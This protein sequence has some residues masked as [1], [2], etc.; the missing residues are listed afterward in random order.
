MN[1][2]QL[3]KPLDT[4]PRRHIGPN[5]A[6][7]EEMLAFLG[8]DSLDDL[9][10]RVVPNT[11]RE[12]PFLD[13]SQI[14]DGRGEAELLAELKGMAQQNQVLR[15]YLGM[16]YHG[17]LTPGVVLRNLLENPGWYTAY[18]PYQA[19]IAQGR[20]EMLLA[21]QTLVSDLTG[22][23]IS[24]ASL[25]DEATA[26]AE[27]VSL[28]DR[29]K[30]RKNKA[31]TFFVDERC[32]PQ[33]IAVVKTR[34]DAADV[35][36]LV[37]DPLTF[38]FAT[39]VFGVLVQYPATDGEIVDYRELVK[40][41]HHSQALAVF[42][43]DLLALTLLTPPGELGADVVIGCS[44]R[45][46][47]PM[48]FGG[49]HAAFMAT[50]EAYKR[51]VPGRIIGVSQD[52]HGNPALRM[53]L[54]TR[55]QH[56]RRQ[57]ATSNICTAQV[58]LAVVAAAY[59]IYH[60]PEGITAIAR[61]V[62]GMTALL[63][64]ELKARGL[65]LVHE[66]Y[67]DTLRVRGDHVAAALAAGFNL[68]AYQGD[69][70]I[71]LDETVTEQDL[72]DLLAV[73]DAQLGAADVDSAIP[74]GLTRTSGFL[75]N[76]LF[77]RYHSEHE[78]LRLLRKLQGRDL[79]LDTSMIALGSCTMKLNA[80]CQ[81]IPVTWPEFGAMHPFAPAEQTLGYAKLFEQLESWLCAIT[82][83][84]AFSLQPNAGSQGEYAGLL[85]IRGYHHGRG[86]DHRN[87]CLIPTSAHGTNPASAVMVGMKVVAVK[88]DDQ[89]NIDLDDLRAQAA[90]YADNLAALM[91]T[92]PSTHGVFETAIRDICA[93]VHEHGGQ[94]YLDGANMNAQVG[95]ARPGHYGADV[96]HLNLHKTFAIPHGGGGPGMGPIGVRAHLA[97]Y[98]PGHPERAVS[99]APYGSP[100]ILP[101]SWMYIA[102][103]G[104]DGLR[105]STQYA[106]LNANYIARKLSAHFDVLYTGP[107][108]WVAHECILDTRPLKAH[109][110]E[111]DDIA[112]RLMDFGFH[113]PT[114]SFPVSG[115]LMV[116]P[117]ESEPKDELDRFC[118]ALIAIKGEA[119]AIQRGEMDPVD[120]PLKNA[121]HTQGEI[122]GEWTHP[123]SR[124]LAAF[125]APWTRDHKYWP[126]V[127]RIDNA[128]GDRNL[129]CTCPSVEELSED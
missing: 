87:I 26:A 91:V 95:I 123:Y 67:F 90:R 58:L 46:G 57:K 88:C 69:T 78:M 62:H 23:E 104:A 22:M 96:C 12:Q 77:N 59:A 102:A 73:F 64:R 34:A 122:V 33:T 61:R 48:G 56:I 70:C 66:H 53:A 30:S 72:R 3:L 103:L 28:C 7:L 17:T 76:E 2:E 37:G 60:G 97:P 32:H 36:I 109:G 107:G 128:W 84:D 79:A 82:G 8:V 89:G 110:V 106:I 54:Q 119:D 80:T 65:E 45:F 71:A 126:T 10:S 63:A 15:S 93:V 39:P 105:K 92:Y 47:V 114:M 81:M 25:L 94:V 118:D 74:A 29:V 111:V 44:Q 113:A 116:E 52:R 101:I 43:A 4:F 51:S 98:L 11:I 108:G 117:T 120:N 18:T 100:S 115:T 35:N 112:K 129:M 40:R 6:Q 125:P 1:V 20:L 27:A 121:P 127:A 14:P 75:T 16:G 41:C 85:A 42:A 24:N 86:D 68:R 99:A 19:E 38:D 55:E 9:V 124:E 31:N 49:P 13:A 50:R 21:F 5:A 83:F